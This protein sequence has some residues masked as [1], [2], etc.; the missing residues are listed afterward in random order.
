[1]LIFGILGL[2]LAGSLVI[3][4]SHSIKPGIARSWVIAVGTAFAAWLLLLYLRLYLPTDIPLLTWQSD[5]FMNAKFMLVLSYQSWPYAMAVV[6]LMMASFL[7][8]STRT[9]LA[10]MPTSWSGLLA[11]AALTLLSVLAGNALTMMFNWMLLDLVKLIYL[12]TLQHRGRLGAKLISSFALHLLSV[13]LLMFATTLAF[14]NNPNFTFQSIPPSTGIY[15]LIAAALRVGVLPLNLPFLDAPEL[16][17][18]SGLI[19]RFFPV[20]SALVLIGYLPE[21]FL[22]VV[23]WLPTTVKALS[24]LAAL[25]SALM[26]LTRSTQQEARPYWIVAFSAFAVQC[27]LYGL[28]PLSRVWGL[29]LLLGGGMLFL[30]DP[31]IRRIRY[32]PALG[33]LSLVGL[34]YTPAASGWDGLLGVGWRM[35]AITSLITHAL[36]VLG[37]IRFIYRA[38]S[39]ITGLENYTRFTY[40]LAFIFIFQTI[41]ILGIV[42]WPGVLTTG[43]WRAAL[44]SLILVT[45]GVLLGVK[46][47]PHVSRAELTSQLPF[48]RLIKVILVNLEYF[49]SLDWLMRLADWFVK[50]FSNI[51]NLW[52]QFLEGEGGILWML[53]FLT[54]L[55]FLFYS[56]VVAQ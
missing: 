10:D 47:E 56:S 5:V 43:N 7:T 11:L 52:N 33:L 26:I 2:L 23:V 6:T 38:R 19:I 1:M 53:V 22:N 25:Y 20:A 3:L 14:K 21:D 49:F 13:G 12:L 35:P 54:I 46:L 32:L 17:Y 41:I 24:L 15:F 8:D 31:P 27:S 48:Y 18:G 42:G 29:A 4:I 30:F 9:D 55:M 37:Y 39:P 50:Q 16:R 44:V 28:A 36:L 34:P 45:I 40:P 51:M